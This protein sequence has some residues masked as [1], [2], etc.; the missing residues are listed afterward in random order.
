LAPA[1][2]RRVH[3]DVLVFAQPHDGGAQPTTDRPSRP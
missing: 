1:L 3:S 2:H